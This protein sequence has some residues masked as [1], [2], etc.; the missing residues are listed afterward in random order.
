MSDA[1]MNYRSMVDQPWG[2]M[3]YDMIYKQLDLSD[4]KKLKILDFGAGFCITADHY[5]KSHD[6]TAVEPN[7]EM[8]A[9]RVG[10]NPYTLVGGGIDYLRDLD[11]DSF[12]LVICHNV[13]EYADD[14]EAILK[15][16]VRVTKPGGILSVVKHNL[17]GRVMATAVMSDDPKTALGLLDQGAE[18]SM[19]GK[20]DVYSNEWITDLLK[21]EMTLI[22]TYGIRTFFGLSSNN[23]IK[24]TDDWYQSMLELETKA[25]SM[26]EYRKVAFFNH[27]IFAKKQNTEM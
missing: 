17:Y 16:L 21:D 10:D 23:D 11:A 5:A 26:D 18:N 22:D 7:D 1:I 9:L 14:K 4:C 25:C 2:R 8:R 15:H 3:F 20:R 6:V 19:F 12:D 27:L 24:Y 13:L